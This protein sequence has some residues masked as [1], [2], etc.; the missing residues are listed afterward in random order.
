MYGPFLDMDVLRYV[1]WL[2]LYLEFEMSANSNITRC[3]FSVWM[4]LVAIFFIPNLCLVIP[5][6]IIV[7][8]T[9]VVYCIALRNMGHFFAF[10]G[11]EI[12]C[13]KKVIYFLFATG[14]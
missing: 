13:L 7:I 12:S 9:I 10:S 11:G 14:L 4:L 1:D 3:R 5:Q 6:K 8:A 2:H